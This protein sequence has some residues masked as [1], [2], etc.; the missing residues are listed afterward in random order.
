LILAA[1]AWLNCLVKLLY[2]IQLGEGSA[3]APAPSA[4]NVGVVTSLFVFGE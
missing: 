2:L 1:A 4:G 3:L